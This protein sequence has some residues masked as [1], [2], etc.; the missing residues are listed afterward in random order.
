[1]QLCQMKECAEGKQ[2]G[3]AVWRP[4]VCFGPKGYTR[5]P[6]NTV[7]M[8]VPLGLCADHKSFALAEFLGLNRDVINSGFAD[9]GKAEPDLENAF[10]EFEPITLGGQA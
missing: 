5:T 2:P 9:L 4:V 3:P 10:V 7:R 1:M 6:A 8:L